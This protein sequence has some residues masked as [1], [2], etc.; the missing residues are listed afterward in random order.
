MQTLANPFQHRQ[1]A[2]RFLEST[3]GGAIRLGTYLVL[4][5]SA[6]IFLTIGIKGGQAVL[7]PKWPFV[8]VAFFTEKPSTLYVFEWHGQKV[9]MSD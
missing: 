9:E 7:T 2:N 4:L 6:C 1:T 8:N 5:A 3:V